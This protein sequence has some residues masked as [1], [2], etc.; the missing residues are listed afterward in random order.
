MKTALRPALVTAICLLTHSLPATIMVPLTVEDLSQR[1]ELV[2]HGTVRGQHCLTD[3]EG[4]IY[5][6]IELL[7]SE[8]WKGRLATNYF[9]LVHGGGTVGN[10]T[11]VVGGQAAY[12]VGEEIVAY[13]QLNQRGEGV[14]IG[15]AQGKFHVWQDAATGEKFAHNLFH[16]QPKA[17]EGQPAG[18]P[19]RLSLGEL[20]RHA[21][22]GKQ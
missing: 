20:K 18:K 8:V 11:T 6:K 13:L 10:L 21:L 15:L 16:G 9:V 4:R 12:E 22:G 1:A 19:A 17:A 2:L 5:T 14:S 7:V 3:A